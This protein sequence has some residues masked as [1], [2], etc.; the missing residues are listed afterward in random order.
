M[1]QPSHAPPRES[2]ILVVFAHPAFER[3]RA[4]RRLLEAAGSLDLVTVHDL[5]EEYPDFDIDVAREQEL[6]LMHDTIVLQHPFLWYSGPSLLKEWI[7]LVWEHG[8]A[9]GEGG[10]ALGGKTILN[11]VTTGGTRESYCSA[12]RN[13]R[14]VRDLLAPF[15]QSAAICGM[16]F[17]P[18]FAVHNVHHLSDSEI[19][20]EAMEYRALLEALG[21][22]SLPF[23]ELAGLACL[24]DRP[25]DPDA[26]RSPGMAGAPHPAES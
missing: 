10:D 7:D 22:G 1:T 2:R 3:S 12:G 6:L 15:E 11:A 13:R 8:F 5:Y 24:N 17:L 21:R 16:R 25:S 14:S 26:P 23:G 18:P 20:R 9:Y 4:N 19:A